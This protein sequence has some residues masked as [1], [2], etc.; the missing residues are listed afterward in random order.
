MCVVFQI[1]FVCGGA[2]KAESLKTILNASTATSA[3]DLLPAARVV[4][5]RKGCSVV[6]FVDR[7][8]Y[9]AC[10]PAAAL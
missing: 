4:A 7:A 10:T 5:T 9:S 6:W 2:S 8:A 3:D 1:A